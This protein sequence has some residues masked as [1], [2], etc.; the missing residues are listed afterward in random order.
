MTIRNLDAIFSPRSIAIIGASHR[1]GSLGA[2][3][4]RNMFSGGFDGPIMPVHPRESHIQSVQAYPDIKSLPMVPDL[5]VVATP[6]DTV[7]EIIA[8]LGAAGTRGVVVITAGFAEGENKAGRALEQ[9]M[10]DAAKPH[11]LRIVGPNC[12]G[13]LVP[14]IGMNASFA[15]VAPK[16][17]KIA[18]LTQSGAILTT[19]LDWASG[20]N[21]GFSHLVSLGDMSD[22]DFGDMLDYLANDPDVDAILLY[23]EAVTHARKFMSAARAAA[24]MKPVIVV[25]SGRHP[26]GAKAAASHTGALAGSDDVYDAA[27][28]RAGMLRVTTLE[29][30]FDAVETLSQIQLPAGDR[31]ALVTNGGGIGVLAADA[32]IDEGGELAELAPE[33]IAALDKILPRTWSHG[34]PVDIIGDAP[35]ARYQG[36]MEAVLAD[37]NVDGVIAFHCP[38]AVADP[39]EAAEA[40]IET[41]KASPYPVLVNWLGDPAVREARARFQAAGIPSYDTPHSAVRAFMHLVTYRQNQNALMET[42]PSVQDSCE[43]DRGAARAIIDKALGDGREWLTDP[44][45]KAVLEAYGI[46]VPKRIIAKDTEEAGKAAGEIGAPVALKILSPDITHKSDVGG[47]TLDLEGAEAT[48][49]A[50]RAM[51]DHVHKEKP[52]ATLAGFVV[53]EMVNRPNAHELIVGVSTDALFG[54]MILFGQ[55]GIAV[56]VIADRALAMPPLNLRLAEEVMRRTRVYKLLKGYRDRP[57]ADLDAIKLTLIR[58]S[59]M[60]IDFAEIQEL[61]I[62]PLLAGPDSVIALDARIRVRPADKLAARLA[63]RPYP[64]ALEETLTTDDGQSFLLRPVMPEDEPSLQAT[65]ATLTPEEI[66]LR[67]FAPIKTLPHVQAARFTQIDYDR[68]MALILT[69][70]GVPGEAEIFGVVRL[71]ADPDNEQAEYAILVRHDVAGHGLGHKMMERITDYARKRG[72]GEVWGDVLRENKRMLAICDDLGF[73]R[74]TVDGEPSI[75]KVR[76]KFT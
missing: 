16:K 58:I 48:M 24:R 53:E 10:L 70:P 13:V 6:P 49:E 60:I 27:F 57:A 1:P 75:V 62:N 33:T 72:I 55:G 25:K 50:A 36:A 30:L 38:V 56:E 9:K 67:F 28:R 47:V 19:V 73:E 23:V 5:A 65:F 39:T 45:A 8:E 59:Q 54:P 40:V 46:S 29:D 42:P 2:V 31:L 11:L 69:K 15:H 43:P 44:E 32:V 74:E 35:G 26:E 4:A 68:E 66:R 12:L 64:S 22:V 63:I 51:R 21:I 14:G 52:D 7:P 76:L 61:D 3:L 20:R 71:S 18:F 41:A 37:D 17:G 34:N